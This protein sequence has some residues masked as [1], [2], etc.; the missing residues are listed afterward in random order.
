MNAVAISLLLVSQEPGFPKRVEIDNV[1]DWPKEGRI[2]VEGVYSLLGDSAGTAYRRMEL[3]NCSVPFNVPRS[4][5]SRKSPIGNI[6]VT[7]VVEM[8]NGKRVVQVEDF[9][10]LNDDPSRF[11][12][13]LT[14]AEGDPEKLY[15]A[16]AWAKRRFELYK[17]P[18]MNEAVRRANDAGLLAERKNAAGDPQKLAALQTKL[19]K[20]PPDGGYDG[21]SLKHEIVRAQFDKIAKDDAKAFMAFADFVQGQLPGAKD[22][23]DAVDPRHRHNYDAKPLT[24]YDDAEPGLRRALERYFYSTLIDKA[25][26]ASFQKDGAAPFELAET[27]KKKIPEYREVARRW[28]RQWAKIQEGRL[29]DLEAG[30]ASETARIVADELEEFAF[31][32]KLR[33]EW[34][35]AREVK[36]RKREKESAEESGAN[37]VQRDA[38]AW[39]ELAKQRL[40]WFPNSPEHEAKAVKTLEDVLSF[41]PQFTKAEVELRN[42]GYTQSTTGWRRKQERERDPKKAGHAR[43]LAVNM[44]AAEVLDALGK[45]TYRSRMVTATGATVVWIYRSSGGD[46]L[47]VLTGPAEAL[48]VSKIQAPNN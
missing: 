30:E 39:F 21:D 45:P 46:T 10:L 4:L 33:N 38:D 15:A 18:A 13:M 42:L 44:T 5:L 7:G 3:R 8:A 47:V 9:S 11:E 48:R 35:D 41:A 22:I 37:R 43:G 34:L 6:E 32:A 12:Q 31:A 19:T 24:T 23:G 17:A 20:S 36:I 29:V 27:A 25:L 28:F 40:A 26:A 16:A 14:A 2:V 1:N